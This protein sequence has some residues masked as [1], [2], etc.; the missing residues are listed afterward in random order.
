MKKTLL[1]ITQVNTWYIPELLLKK[2]RFIDIA[3]KY[4]S[5]LEK[6]AKIDNESVKEA[7]E[8]APSLL[9]LLKNNRDIIKC[10]SGI[11]DVVETRETNHVCLI[12]IDKK[13]G[14]FD[15]SLNSK[16]TKI[17]LQKDKEALLFI[18]KL[19]KRLWRSNFHKNNPYKKREVRKLII[20]IEEAL[21]NINESSIISSFE[22]AEDIRKKWQLR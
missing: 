11:H 10:L 18:K 2:A 5:G 20:N 13:E 15:P 21:K 9:S 17:V 1:E 7:I 16:L 8:S 12:L 6:K 14:G 22:L 19:L 3:N 4:Y